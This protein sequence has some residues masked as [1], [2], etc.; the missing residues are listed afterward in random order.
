MINLYVKFNVHSTYKKQNIVQNVGDRRTDGP[1][2][3][4]T[5]IGFRQNF[6]RG[7]R[8]LKLHFSESITFGISRELRLF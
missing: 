5:T 1:L 7:L 6:G 3:L 4:V 8:K 2:R